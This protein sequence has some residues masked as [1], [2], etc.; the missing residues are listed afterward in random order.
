[1]TIEEAAKRAFETYEYELGNLYQTTFI[2][3][4]K[5]GAEWQRKND[6]TIRSDNK[7][8]L[9]NALEELRK[10]QC[11]DLIKNPNDLPPK[12]ER[13]YTDE[14]LLLASTPNGIEV[15]IGNY[16]YGTE[17]WSYNIPEYDD[18]WICGIAWMNVPTFDEILE[19]NKDVLERLKDK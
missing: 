1:M 5:L 17:E 4:F 3:G 19:S 15:I 8:V 11:H 6:D 12:G 2:G 10:Y 7:E 16:D 9:N 14:V 18:I 13:G